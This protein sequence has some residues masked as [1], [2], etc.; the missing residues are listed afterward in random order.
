MVGISS[1]GVYV[2]RSRLDRALIAK[3]W[4]AKQPP[5]EKA[6]AFYDEDALTLAVAAAHRCLE[7]FDALQIDGL[8]FASTS[9]PYREKQVASVVAT[10]CDLPREIVTADFAGSV[11]AGLAA[12]SAAVRAVQSGQ[13]R[14][15]LVV[16][17]DCRPAEP[18]SDLEGTLGDAAV[19]VVVDGK[20][21]LAEFVASAAVAEEFTF[22]WRSNESSGV[23][24]QDARFSVTHGYL[25]D[26]AEVIGR[27]MN[28][29]GVGAGDL[30]ALAVG[31]PDARTA[32]QLAKEVGVDA[33]TRLVPSLIPQI[34]VTGSPDP[35]LQLASALEK[36][37]P[38]DAIV[39]AAFGEGAEALLFRATAGGG[40]LAGRPGLGAAIE[41]KLPLPTYEKYL[42]YRRILGQDETPVELVS[43]VLEARELQQDTRLYGTRCGECGLVQYPMARVCLKCK[44]RQGLEPVKLNKK[45]TIFTYT[46]DHLAA[47]LDHPMGMV[48]VDLEGGGRV[49]VQM[50][51]CTPDEVKIG[52]PVEL[53]FRR[54][55]AGGENY[56]YF[57]KARP[58]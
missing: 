34:G 28:E 11:R 10:A 8:F 15:V 45:G 12:L 32:Q 58:L 54:L 44:A 50:T 22:Q 31:T 48:V 30:A 1:I 47:N 38:A 16:A 26:M 41:R 33:R 7:D 40:A 36:A 5:G 3:A 27:V 17:S 19:A 35:L 57:W 49:Y 9:S 29:H 46:V 21:R 4:G 13:A 18:E 56:N 43:N 14:R 6:V 20:A 25:R 55:H 37:K 53:T 39:T 51:D 52:A 24:T 2:P 23:Q 42:K